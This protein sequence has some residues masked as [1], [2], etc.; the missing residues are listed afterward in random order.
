MFEALSTQSD[1]WSVPLDCQR[2]G[3]TDQVSGRR[4]ATLGS[5]KLKRSHRNGAVCSRGCQPTKQHGQAF[6]HTHIV[7]A[8]D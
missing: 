1:N 5:I 2:I 6:D 4:V 7:Q 3:R 8:G